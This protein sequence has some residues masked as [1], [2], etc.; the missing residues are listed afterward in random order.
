MKYQCYLITNIV[1]GKQY[2][3]MTKLGYVTRF[4][5]HFAEAR[6][7]HKQCSTSSILHLDMVAYG[8]EAFQVELL[9]DDIPQEAHEDRE[10]VWI[11]KLHTYY[12]EGGYNMTFGGNGTVGYMFTDEVRAKLSA[13]NKG[14]KF[15]DERNQHIKE[16]MTGR[17][18]KQ[19]WK[20]A[21]SQARKGRFTGKD[22]PF[23]GKHHSEATKEKLR[24][25][26]YLGD[27]LQ[28][29]EEGQ[30]IGRFSG[31]YAAGK[32][33][34]DSGISDAKPTT[35]GTRIREVVRS[36]N[37]KCTAYGFHW[38]IIEERSID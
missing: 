38:A 10:K 14:K 33:I 18:Y 35:C 11:A 5:N 19:E 16:I 27:V 25:A 22:N 4:H 29:N 24:Q 7:E 21:L 23:Y 31:F 30:E 20:D 36:N 3:G 1:S 13:I 26:R 6:Y 28:L 32:Y 12:A 2:V 37:P 17:E 8:E 34:H 9:E 15:S